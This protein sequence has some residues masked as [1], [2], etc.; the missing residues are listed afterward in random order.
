VRLE[1]RPRL[2]ADHVTSVLCAIL[3][4]ESED[5]SKVLDKIFG[6]KV[7][8]DGLIGRG[9]LE[10][11]LADGFREHYLHLGPQWISVDL[12]QPA[13][14]RYGVIYEYGHSAGRRD[15]FVGDYLV[16]ERGSR[17]TNVPH[18][19]RITHWCDLPEIPK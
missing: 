1:L 6:D 18:G 7:G 16:D 13:P 11:R 8:E 15:R 2:M 9:A 3:V 12:K 4:C 14:G 10:C 17:W 5:E 19:C